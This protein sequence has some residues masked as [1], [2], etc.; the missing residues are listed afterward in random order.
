MLAGPFIGNSINKAMNIPLSDQASADVMTTS[1][2]PAPEI[3]LA[4]AI[5]S[6]LMLALIPLLS[7][8]MKKEK[9]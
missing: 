4:A 6:A 8:F 7:H 5:C 2:V 1:Y 9:K 3:F